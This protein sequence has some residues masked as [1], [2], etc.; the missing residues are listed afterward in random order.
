MSIDAFCTI[1]SSTKRNSD[2]GNGI[3]GG[4]VTYLTSLMITPLYPLSGQTVRMLNLSGAQ[5][6]ET[7]ECFHLP[8][9]GSALPDVREGDRL[10]LDGVE[11]PVSYVAEW[12]DADLPS[13]HIVVGEIKG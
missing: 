7:K 5:L 12:Q 8:G 1:Q 9:A 11:Y 6:R 13:L 4:A 2:L 3:R 10:V